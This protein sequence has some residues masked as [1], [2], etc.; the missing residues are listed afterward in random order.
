MLHTNPGLWIA[1]AACF[2]WI[3]LVSAISFMEAWL[4]FR[5]PGVT[6]AIGLGIGKRVFTALNRLEWCC[7]AILIVGVVLLPDRLKLAN[8][9]CFALAL[10]IVCIQTIFW[11][12]L[13][14]K[15]ADTLIEGKTYTGK[16]VHLNYVIA[17]IVKVLALL[18]GA[19][20][21]GLQRFS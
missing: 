5:A 17:E 1:L 6:K 9:I 7:A 14:K 4:K 10:L 8:A 2:F 11:L 13:L 15:Q 16:S 12:P 19:I 21:L 18:A 3:G 20:L